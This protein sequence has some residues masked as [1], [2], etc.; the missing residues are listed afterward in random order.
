MPDFR[1]VLICGELGKGRL[2]PIARELLGTGRDLSD[3]LHEELGIVL[4]GSKIGDDF[5][6]DATAHGA[7][8]VYIADDP[9]FENY[10]GDSYLN[11]MEKLCHRINPLI[12]LFGQS[13]MGR[14][15]APRLAFRLGTGLCMDCVDLEIDSH[16]KTLH[17]TRP[18]YGGNAMATFVCNDCYPQIATIRAKSMPPLAPDDSRENQVIPLDIPIDDSVVRAKFLKSVK[19]EMKGIKLEDADVI[20]SGGRGIGSEEAFKKLEELATILGGAIGATR[21]PC[22]AGWVPPTIQIGLTGKIVAPDLYIAIGLSGSNQHLAGCSG[23]KIMVAVNTDP[24]AYIFKVAHYGIEGDYKEV[25]PAFTEKCRELL[26]R[27]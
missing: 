5:I 16:S 3:Q 14:D 4:I 23:S 20:I 19:Q 22:D 15:L 7:D 25:L 2:L 10:N 26:D 27:L 1:G 18:V 8:K 9:L 13:S 11:V 6:R 21:A 17:M 24:D 12:L